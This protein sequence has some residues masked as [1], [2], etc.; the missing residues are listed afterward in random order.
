MLYTIKIKDTQLKMD[1]TYSLDIMSIIYHGYTVQ[2]YSHIYDSYN[3]ELRDTSVATY[4]IKFR[5]SN[6]ILTIYM[7]V[8][9]AK[10]IENDIT[11]EI[12]NIYST[13]QENFSKQ[14]STIMGG[15]L[16]FTDA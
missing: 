2:K 12:N 13:N 14:F 1:Y 3:K 4:V 8:E 6:E 11:E 7:S 9:K 10:E 15:E 5:D 16:N